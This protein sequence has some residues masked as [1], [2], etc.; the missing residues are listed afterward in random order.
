MITVS[1]D[2]FVATVDGSKVRDLVDLCERLA[3]LA[4]EEVVRAVV[5]DLTAGLP[6]EVP[7]VDA[8]ELRELERVDLPTIVAVDGDVSGAALDLALAADIRL[9]TPDTTFRFS[10]VGTRRQMSL[11]R[12]RGVVEVQ[13]LG[14]AVDGEAALRLG[15]AG[16][17]HPAGAVLPAAQRLATVIA[18]R[19]PIATR[20]A[21]EAIWRGIEMPL[22]HALRFETD[23]TLLLQ[24]TNDRAEGVRAFLEKRPPRFTGD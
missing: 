24:T 2:G 11:L 8:A 6:P 7:V 10:V 13:R 9:A 20:F 23:L 18:S 17:L 1:D 22:E 19:G 12:Q 4:W 15:L 21:N 5:I 3:S 16:S 14:A